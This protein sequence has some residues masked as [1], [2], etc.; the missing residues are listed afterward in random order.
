MRTLKSRISK[1]VNNLLNA[2]IKG[3][4]ESAYIYYAFANWCNCEGF[5]D[6][7]DKFRKYGDEELTHARK[8]EDYV[9]DKNGEVELEVIPVFKDSIKS[10]VD[11]ITKAYEHEL[12]VS[13]NYIKLANL[14]SKSDVTTFSFIQWFI[15]EQIEEEAKFGDVL[16]FAC[17]HGITDS[18]TGADL[19]ILEEKFVE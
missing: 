13:D 1:E 2:R 5:F 8:L 18:S 9:Y 19:H 17:S 12:I 11:V 10:L 4:Y 14:L 16:A 6:A 15:N 3:E 7:R